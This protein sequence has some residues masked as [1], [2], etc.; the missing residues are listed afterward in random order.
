LVMMILI[1]NIFARYL[2]SLNRIW[3]NQVLAPFPYCHEHLHESLIPAPINQ[4]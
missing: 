2:G 4:P 3:L 1:M